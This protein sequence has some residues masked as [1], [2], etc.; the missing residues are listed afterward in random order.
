MKCN[1]IISI[2]YPSKIS[3]SPNKKHSL[4]F[5]YRNTSYPNSTCYNSNVGYNTLRYSMFTVQH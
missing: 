1:K 4:Y 5:I 3:H 2:N